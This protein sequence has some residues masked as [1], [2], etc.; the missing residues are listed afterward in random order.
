ML[1][2]RKGFTGVVHNA[3]SGIGFAAD[4]PTVYEFPLEMFVTGSDL[5]PLREGIDHI[6]Y[7]LTKWEPEIKEKGIYAP[8]QVTVEGS[9]YQEALSRMNLL[10]LNNMWSDGL[11]LL[12][13]TEESVNWILTGTD[14]PRDTVVGEG[15]ILPRGGIATVESL[16]VALAM[17][18][19]R[20][21]YLPVVIAAVEAIT[22][23]I[24]N[25]Q[26]WQATTGNY[27]PA[28]VVNGPIG[29]QIRLNSGYGCLGPD[30]KHPASG[31]IG[32]AIRLVLMNLG[33]AI[34]GIGTMALH[35]MNRHVNLVFAEEEERLPETWKPVS[36][37]YGLAKGVNA[38]TYFGIH[39]GLEDDQSTRRSKQATPEDERDVFLESFAHRLMRPDKD[40]RWPMF[41]PYDSA[42]VKAMVKTAPLQEG[43][44]P[45]L[46][47]LAYSVAE[48][49][50]NLWGWSKEDVVRE[51][52][53]K[54]RIPW[55]VIEQTLSDAE[56]DELVTQSEGFLVKGQPWPTV[57][58][59]EV[60]K[61]V[62][63]G[64]EQGGHT[65]FL[66]G[67]GHGQQAAPREIQLPANWDE[68]L[69]QAEEDL[70]PIPAG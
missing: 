57:A 35:G 12:P 44:R 6:I 19:G 49:F 23:P 65:F 45:S 59:P 14:L 30:P 24:S 47:L 5:T 70:G 46:M 50:D 9:D 22:D 15:K 56:I 10:F 18:G 28:L 39:G 63:C 53:E 55:N 20:P 4:A 34:P 32:R 61:I 41:G 54:T 62:V 68:L 69:K 21:E 7:G 52:W 37:E 1:V 60:L 58:G 67:G 40:K 13:A 17:A 8:P 43:K 42:A 66:A 16:A 48:D 33:G 26:G 64:G 38:V 2:T 25:H 29:K 51:V 36:V 27:F 3:F 11:P 31:P